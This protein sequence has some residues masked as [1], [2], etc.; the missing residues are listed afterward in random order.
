MVTLT[1]VKDYLGITVGTYDALLTTFIDYISAEIE[2]YCDR[3]FR[4]AT[5][6]NEPLKFQFTQFD[7]LPI[8][9]YALAGLRAATTLLH[10]PVQTGTITLTAGGNTITEDDGY[11]LKEDEGIVLFYESVS[12]FKENLLATYTAGYATADMPGDLKLVALQGIKDLFQQSGTTSQGGTSGEVASKKVGDFSVTYDTG[13]STTSSNSSGTAGAGGPN[14]F[15][16][17][18]LSILQRYMS[19]GI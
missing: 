14:I 19:I 10:R 9:P 3:K 2:T 6:T 16:L 8:P 15:L 13:S 11:I 18:N 1:E 7:L 12:D 17:N 5:Y 4:E